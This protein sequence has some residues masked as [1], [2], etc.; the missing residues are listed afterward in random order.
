MGV[1]VGEAL[2]EFEVEATAEVLGEVLAAKVGVALVAT[3]RVES[4]GSKAIKIE[5]S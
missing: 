1:I 4:N 3:P 2:A 5:A